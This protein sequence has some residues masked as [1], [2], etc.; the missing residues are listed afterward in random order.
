MA[1]FQSAEILRGDPVRDPKPGRP[2]IK[3]G[4]FEIPAGF[5]AA[6]V[7][8]MIKIPPGARLVDLIYGHEALGATATADVGDALSAN[9]YLSA[10]T[11][12]AIGL[13]RLL[14]GLGVGFRYDA[15]GIITLSFTAV[16]T[17]TVGADIRM[18]ATYAYE[19]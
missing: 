15:L 13:K 2:I 11:H 17:P 16:A 9:R 10:Q 8:Q 18:F 19:E 5:A 7:V 12:T 3:Q 6:D 14:N 4:F 1:I